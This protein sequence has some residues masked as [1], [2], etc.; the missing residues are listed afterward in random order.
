[1]SS[2]SEGD[3]GDY[4]GDNSHQEEG[5]LFL[6]SPDGRPDRWSFFFIGILSGMLGGAL[7]V[8]SPWLAGAL[9]FIGYGLTAVSLRSVRHGF[10]RALRFGFAITAVLGVAVL[11]GDALAPKAAWRVIS[12]IGERHLVFPGFVFMPWILGILRYFYSLVL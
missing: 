7:V 2:D 6:P 8:I 12:A 1:M 3:I 10:G 11:L 4:V 5:T 9:I